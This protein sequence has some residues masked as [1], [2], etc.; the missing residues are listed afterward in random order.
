MTSQSTENPASGRDAGRAQRLTTP[1]GSNEPA[2][3]APVASET[4]WLRKRGE[5]AAGSGDDGTNFEA[6][7]TPF[8]PGGPVAQAAAAPPRQSAWTMLTPA[9]VAYARLY[10]GSR[11]TEND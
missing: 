5:A 3:I 10:L 2:E 8:V 9:E 4:F 7:V 1:F 6:G 11:E